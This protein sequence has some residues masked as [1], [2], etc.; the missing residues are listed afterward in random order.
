MPPKP[1][2]QRISAERAPKSAPFAIPVSLR[3]YHADLN[4]AVDPPSYR[5]SDRRAEQLVSS[6]EG[7]YI[8]LPDGRRA[9]QLCRIS[10]GR[11]EWMERH[12]IFSSSQRS[13]R[14]LPPTEVH[15][16][17]YRAPQNNKTEIAIRAGLI[18]RAR[19]WAKAATA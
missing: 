12:E 7:K 18:V 3:V 16:T 15:G 14:V 4:P 13:L 19:M 11:D 17:R 8:E 9:V 10:A 1:S 5:Q 2:R 6:G